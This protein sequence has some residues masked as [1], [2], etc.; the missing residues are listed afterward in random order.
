MLF[1]SLGKYQGARLLACLVRIYLFLLKTAKVVQPCFKSYLALLGSIHRRDFEDH[2]L[3]LSPTTHTVQVLLIP[4][5]QRISKRPHL[6]Q[7]G[8]CKG[9]P[10]V[11][12]QASCS[13]GEK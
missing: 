6:F 10:I 2:S 11:C 13:H 7:R 9:L 5:L 1:S 12:V 4:P 8:Y 3:S